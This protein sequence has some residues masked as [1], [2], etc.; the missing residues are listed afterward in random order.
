MRAAAGDFYYNS[1]RLVV[2]NVVWGVAFFVVL[3]IWASV[4]PIALVLVPLLAIPWVGVVRIAALIVRRDDVVMSDAFGAYRRWLWPALA[5]GFGLGLAAFA[6]VTNLTIGVQF[7]GILG[8]A[9]TALSFW[10]LVV[11]WVVALS[12]WPLLVDPRREDVGARRKLRVAAVLAVAYPLR[13]AA[14]GFVATV[15]LV[16]STVAIVPIVT[17]SVAYVALMSSRL[18]LIAADRLE[19]GPLPELD[20]D[21]SKDDSDDNATG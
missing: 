12:F 18:V 10:C 20:D 17:I 19:G 7:G 14:L 16:I 9:F 5:A 2:A 4:G 13:L 15:I 1:L 11:A 8:W 21:E 3:T 6:L